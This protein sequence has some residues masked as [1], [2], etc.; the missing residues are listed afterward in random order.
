MANHILSYFPDIDLRQG[1]LG[2]SKVAAMAKR[3][4]NNLNQGDFLLFVNRSQTALK[5]LTTGGVLVHVKSEH[6][7]LNFEAVNMLPQYFSGSA[8]NYKGALKKTLEKRLAKRGR[9]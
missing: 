8:F 1:H 6:G 2:L 3:P 4:L 5:V 9:V 7:R